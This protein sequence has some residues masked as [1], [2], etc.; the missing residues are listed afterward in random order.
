MRRRLMISPRIGGC[1]ITVASVVSAAHQSRDA[2]SRGRLR[3]GRRVRKSPS[4][5]RCDTGDPPITVGTAESQHWCDSLE[6]EFMVSI[7]SG[8][9][10]RFIAGGAAAVGAAAAFGAFA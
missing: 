7:E 3:A 1:P 10:R 6:G 2:Q 5:D 4:H 8:R 9:K